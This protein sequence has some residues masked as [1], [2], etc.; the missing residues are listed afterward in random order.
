MLPKPWG[1]STAPAPLSLPDSSAASWGL[2]FAGGW[3]SA[4]GNNAWLWP[5]SPVSQLED[6][7]LHFR[8]G[9]IP[10]RMVWVLLSANDPACTMTW[11]IRTLSSDALQTLSAWLWFSSVTAMVASYSSSSRMS[12]INC[13]KV[14]A[15]SHWS[16]S[17]SLPRRAVVMEA[18]AR[19]CFRWIVS[20][21]LTDRGL[22]CP[23]FW[24]RG[25]NHT[26]KPEMFSPDFW[27][28]STNCEV[29]WSSLSPKICFRASRHSS[30][31][32][33]TAGPQHPHD[34]L[35]RAT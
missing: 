21:L 19:M 31:V 11:G 15:H 14:G 20:V 29:L 7:H 3:F 17:L 4:L 10:S 13:R 24:I 35:G 16:S 9:T 5:S 34:G 32:R 6:S 8:N 25:S 23:A 28:V 2:G 33:V 12:F 27:K 26:K 30:T 18:R 1:G 22:C